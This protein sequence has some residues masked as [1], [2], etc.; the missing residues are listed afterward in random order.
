M[1]ACSS[2]P[3]ALCWCS[4]FD[5]LAFC[6]GVSLFAVVLDGIGISGWGWCVCHTRCAGAGVGMSFVLHPSFD[7]LVF[8]AGVGL[9][10]VVF[11]GIGVFVV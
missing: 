11:N 8:C 2:Y 4:S 9:F 3:F 1:V 10:V 5:S 7:L 6:T